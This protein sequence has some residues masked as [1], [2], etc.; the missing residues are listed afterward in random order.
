MEYIATDAKD[1]K[2]LTK[3]SYFVSLPDDN[4]HHSIR[5][6]VIFAKIITNACGGAA[7]GELLCGIL[8][9]YS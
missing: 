6:I 7:N 9:Y 5:I 1:R 2:G 8:L 4:Y 3:K